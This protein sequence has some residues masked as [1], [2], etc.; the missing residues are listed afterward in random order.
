MELKIMDITAF[1][2]GVAASI[3]ATVLLSILFWF[4]TRIRFSWSIFSSV[5]NLHRRFKEIGFINFYSSRADYV[6]YRKADKLG[7]YLGFANHQ[8][9]LIG[10]WIANSIEIDGVI[11]DIK[12]LLNKKPTLKINIALIDPNS[13]IISSIANYLDIEV[14]EAKTRVTLSLNKLIKLKTSLDKSLKNRLEIRTYQTLPSFAT[15]LLDPDTDNC[16]V[17]IDFKI[18]HQPRHNSF[19]IEFTGKGKY[20]V[21]I[22]KNSAVKF[23][24]DS[25]EI[26]A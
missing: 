13:Q 14:K 2:L 4:K 7:D 23:F 5:F 25:E 6:R 22:L 21:E 17:Q 1:A 24:Y 20:M 11:N 8:V 18:Y 16:R 15:I 10:L 19:S 26:N 9:Y 3:L 12:N